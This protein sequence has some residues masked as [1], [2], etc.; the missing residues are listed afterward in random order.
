MAFVIIS[1]AAIA[2][3]YLDWEHRKVQML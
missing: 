1:V 3:L 2:Q